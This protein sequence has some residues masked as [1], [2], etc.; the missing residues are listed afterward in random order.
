MQTK[1]KVSLKQLEKS[2]SS[3]S[4]SVR[5][6][7]IF[8]Y[9]KSTVTAEAI[10]ALLRGLHDTEPGVVR[11]AAESLG[12]LGPDALA[13]GKPILDCP[14]VI[15]ELQLVAGR[16][17]EICGTPQSY[18]HCLE[19]LVALDPQND[20]IIG[21]IHDHIGLTNWHPL[22]A[23]LQALKTIGTTEAIDLLNRSVTFWLPELD[24]KQKRI[25]EKI[26]AGKGV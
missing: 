18:I 6:K 17:D 8:D 12:Q 9:S 22:K 20:L 5:Y 23:S 19:A 13:Y 10:P 1:R 15:W 21:L 14:Q 24:K 3:K 11:C 7:A 16:I 25:V 4:R 26:A 2:L